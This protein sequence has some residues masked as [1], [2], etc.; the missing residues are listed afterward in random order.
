[1]GKYDL[2]R[3]VALAI[4]LTS[5]MNKFQITIREKIAVL[6]LA[7]LLLPLIGTA[8]TTPDSRPLVFTHVTVID[9][10]GAPAQPD[11]T[12]VIINGR[13][14]AL[15][16]T[17][18]VNIPANAR[19]IEATGKFLI[20]GL[21]D[22][23]CHLLTNWEYAPLYI[24][25]GVTG[26]RDMGVGRQL[27]DIAQLRKDV[28]AGTV[29]GPRL[30]Y[31]GPIVDAR[32]SN[33]G[34][35]LAVTTLED[36]R[37]AVNSL[38]DAGVDFIKVYEYLSRESFFAI[39][40]EAKKRGLPFAGHL[41]RS[42][43]ASE[44]SDAGQKSMEHVFVFL[45]ACST[46]E[47]EYKKVRDE[48]QAA[49]QKGSVP[50]E[51][52]AS[53]IDANQKLVDGY[54]SEKCLELGKRFVKNGTWQV[55]TFVGNLAYLMP[56]SSKPD[57]PRFRYAPP[58]VVEGWHQRLATMSKEQFARTQ[59]RAETYV[60][61]IR[62]LH[63]VGVRILAGTDAGTNGF[64]NNVPGF[65]L[66]DELVLLVRAGLTPMQALQS[67]TINAAEYLNLA[68][69]LGTIEKG[70]KAELLLLDANPLVDIRNTRKINSVVVNGRLFDRL[71]LD[72]LLS[73]VEADVKK[74]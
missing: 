42:I 67:A 64:I 14:T 66:H 9:A 53:W 28:L 54:S 73:G 32:N 26:V 52:R 35:T 61:V 6:L 44:A 22:M 39:I 33:P 36:A 8:Q 48:Y 27:A 34:M 11:M 12:A 40:E 68:D 20:P 2:P 4:H 71:E 18:K 25:Q 37:R 45:D 41:P 29:I 21:W 5:L 69:S 59:K 19:R 7:L 74:K 3:F 16:K 24:A 63:R 65:S 51:L 49:Q 62:D 15:G 13:I 58:K 55:P 47:A 72:K 46:A 17:G 70:K 38:A 31:A 56:E 23:H 60:Q 10:T 43:T 30:I 50:A 1:M 57:D